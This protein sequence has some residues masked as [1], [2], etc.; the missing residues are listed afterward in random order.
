MLGDLL[1]IGVGEGVAEVDVTE[2][3]EEEE[4]E[5]EVVADKD[6]V[7]P[8]AVACDNGDRFFH[9]IRS[10]ISAANK[11]KGT[12]ARA[13][14]LLSVSSMHTG[15]GGRAGRGGC[16]GG[17]KVSTKDKE[18][19]DATSTVEVEIEVE[20]RAVAVAASAALSFLFLR[21]VSTTLNLSTSR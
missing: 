13:L 4:E 3:K 9:A 14:L 16:I 7:V 2:C 6:R 18:D 19:E 15:A 8:V 5:E 10:F 11:Q 17:L 1:I 21:D 20:G 12:P